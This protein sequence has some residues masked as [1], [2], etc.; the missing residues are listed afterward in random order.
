MCL[1][2]GVR[3]PVCFAPPAR[4]WMLEVEGAAG[5]W[6]LGC[7]FLFGRAEGEP[8]AGSCCAPSPHRLC[9]EI[10]TQNSSPVQPA[11]AFLRELL[12]RSRGT[13]GFAGGVGEY[14]WVMRFLI[15]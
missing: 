7:L 5:E 11:S 3:R 2:A 4:G 13:S 10:D 14:D 12:G 15:P 8:R 1:C 6:A 9:S